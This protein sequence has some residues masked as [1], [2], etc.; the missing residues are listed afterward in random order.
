ML[1]SRRTEKLGIDLTQG[2]VGRGAEAEGGPV[3][4][5]QGYYTS[6]SSAAAWRG[7]AT[8]PA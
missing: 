7:C 1:T 8:R 2:K 5:E 6:E 4:D 3:D